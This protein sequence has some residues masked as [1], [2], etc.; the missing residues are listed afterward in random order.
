MRL[1]SLISVMALA[2]LPGAVH[3]LDCAI[4]A[5]STATAGTAMEFALACDG[6]LAARVAWEFGDGKT[7]DYAAQPKATHAYAAPGS[8][9]VFARIEGEDFPATALI[10]VLNA[11][12]KVV[13]TRSGTLLLDRARGRLWNVNTDNN[14]VAVISVSSLIRLKEIPVGRAPRTLAQDPKGRIW[15]A[16]QDDATLTVLDGDVMEPLFTVALPRASRPYGICF[17]PSGLNAY[18]T[19]EASGAILRLDPSDGRIRDSLPLFPT[20][21]GIAVAPDGKTLWVTRFISPKDHGEVAQVAAGPFALQRIIVLAHDERQDTESNGRGVPN[22]LTSLTISPDGLRAWVPFKKDNTKRGMR[23]SGSPDPQGPQLPTFESTVRTGVGQIDLA[24]GKEIP[25]VRIDLDNRSLACAVAFA[26]DGAFAFVATETSNEIAVIN[27]AENARA[28]AIEPREAGH[29]LGP[30]GL[31]V[32]GDD[33]V[34]FIHDFLSREIAVYGIAEVGGSNVMPRIALI[35]TVGKERLAPEVLK[36][37]QIFYNAADP[38]MARH[39]Y[40]SCA[41]CHLD[42]G[43]DGRV[44]DFTHKGEGLRRTTSLLGKAGLGQGPLHWSANF[45]EVQDFEHDMRDAFQGTGF[46]SDAAF[47]QGSVNRPLGDK[48][49][50]L[51]PGLDALAAY[52]TSLVRS[53]PSPYRRPDG[54]MTD[55][56]EEGEKIFNRPDVGC[57]ACHV[58]PLYTDSRLVPAPASVLDPPVSGSQASAPGAFRTAEGFLLHDVGTLKPESGCRLGDSLRGLDT[59]TLKGLWEGESYLHDG[60]A[61]TLMDVITTANPQDRHGKTSQLSDPERRRLVA[62]L[63]ELDDGAE[64][65]GILRPAPGKAAGHGSASGFAISAAKAGEGMCFTLSRQSLLSSPTGKAGSG[66]AEVMPR[67]L[68]IRGLDGSLVRRLDFPRRG[69]G[70]EATNSV[71]WDGRDGRS[72]RCSPGM[73]LIMAQAQPGARAPATTALTWIP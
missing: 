38:R 43:T 39:K 20:P 35:P 26:R 72:R 41:V 36:G 73:Y 54:S 44:W 42:G 3:A 45:D 68:D 4:R 30:D 34:L 46:L 29:E 55:E 7:L 25:E 40:L 59:P 21:R 69:N 33:S 62:F 67:G 28:T 52:V 8:Y 6:P 70:S 1:R 71:L 11:V 22:G 24:S 31:E 32:S 19:L 16:N 14:S 64:P 18:V 60:S 61:S 57:A 51:S 23:L 66:T 15:V 9:P 17:D 58:P 53:R 47:G 12:S 37:K 10:T 63:M 65:T 2:G 49:T 13:P 50:G 5:D 27:A 56:A 48:K